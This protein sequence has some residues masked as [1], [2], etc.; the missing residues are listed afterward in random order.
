MTNEEMLTDLIVSTNQSYLDENK[1]TLTA[2][3]L[4]FGNP[5]AGDWNNGA[6]TLI[7]VSADTQFVEG[8]YAYYYS[9]ADM[10][11]AFAAIGVNDP[12]V[13]VPDPNAV[14]VLNALRK[15]YNF[16]LAASEMKDFVKDGDQYVISVVSRSLVWIGELRVSVGANQDIDL[17]QYLPNNVLS[18]LTYNPPA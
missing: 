4:K 11:Q 7:G 14:T 16:Q 10:Q 15:K 6:N 12:I 18:G 8:N 17:A 2:K 9:R 13:D 1:V 3:D 5:T